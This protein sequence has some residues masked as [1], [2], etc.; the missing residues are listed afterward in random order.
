MME[1][2]EFIRNT[3]LSA[4]GFWLSLRKTLWAMGENSDG[5]PYPVTAYPHG[6]LE[7]LAG[8]KLKDLLD[9]HEKQLMEEYIPF[10]E[11]GRVD[12]EHGGYFHEFNEDGTPAPYDKH[13]YFQGRGL[14][15]HAYL[16]NHFPVS[17]QLKD[18]LIKSRDFLV[19]NALDEKGYWAS[20]LS[21]DEGKPLA[22]STNIYGDMYMVLGLAETY[23]AT[24]NQEDIELAIQTAY[25]ITERI[26][27]PAYQHLASHGSANEPGTKRLGTW[28]HFLCTLTQLLR[29][30]REG[31]VER[32]ARM[33]VRNI[34][35]HHWQ[36]DSR[37]YLEV[38]DNQ[39]RP[40]PPGDQRGSGGWHGIQAAFV[41]MD[42]ALRIGNVPMFRD[43]ME[44]G[45]STLEHGWVDERGLLSS[46]NP[47]MR[48]EM[49][50]YS[51][52]RLPSSERPERPQRQQ[53][54][55]ALDDVL[56]FCLLAL[57]HNHET[58]A[59]KYYDKAFELGYSHP[60]NWLKPGR[61]RGG[62][63]GLFHHPRRLFYSIEILKRMVERGG[64]PSNFLE[65]A[66]Y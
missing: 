28:A 61:S 12:Q 65:T 51:R 42:E 40:F 47:E 19:K 14:W 4:V 6:V 32:I 38:L 53:P 44:T 15:I 27:D 34:L 26:V 30:R 10:F 48:P 5:K 13:M 39:F 37:M 59:I 23:L 46:R 25:K 21:S 64:K 7:E 56:V 60:E 2:R 31:G 1:R 11:K 66:A 8:K 50:S 45:I 22:P 17:D 58:L 33:C 3:A 29:I 24:K 52:R 16:V 41:A 43:A 36:P 18:S 9:F 57:E 54:W 62:Q 20:V 49:R 55:G 63:R 35:N